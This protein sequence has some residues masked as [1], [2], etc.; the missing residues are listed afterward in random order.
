MG[1]G[2]LAKK[3]TVRCFYRDAAGYRTLSPMD[4]VRSLATAMVIR[5]FFTCYNITMYIFKH[6]L[7]DTHKTR[8]NRAVDKKTKRTWFGGEMVLEGETTKR[9]K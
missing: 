8:L 6:T 9:K 4:L 5:T 1:E 7:C 3:V 2:K